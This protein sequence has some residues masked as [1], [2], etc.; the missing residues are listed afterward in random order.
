[1]LSTTINL[2][3]TVHSYKNPSKPQNISSIWATRHNC[4]SN[5]LSPHRKSMQKKTKKQQLNGI[6]QNYPVDGLNSDVFCVG[7][8]YSRY[9]FNIT[10][11]F[12]KNN[13]DDNLQPQD[14]VIPI[15]LQIYAAIYI[16][17]HFT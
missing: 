10:K 4:A 12:K 16:C 3:K 9:H 11:K 17:K 2:Q 6:K 8:S 5:A 15:L 1:M 13:H 14:I 7:S